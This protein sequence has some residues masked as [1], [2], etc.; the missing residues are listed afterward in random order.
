MIVLWVLVILG[1]IGGGLQ[2]L[3]VVG[4]SS[5]SAP[6]QAGAMSI[7]IGSAV[8]PYC[9]ARAIQF[10]LRSFSN[11]PVDELRRIRLLL[12]AQARPPAD[13]P[14][15]PTNAVTSEFDGGAGY[16][17][18]RCKHPVELGIDRCPGCDVQFVHKSKGESG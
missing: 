4:S 6:Q 13:R 1:C 18:P 8:I 7:A 15:S 2:L 12:E 10:A 9:F 17:C 3:A 11:P 16:R 5:I 14:L